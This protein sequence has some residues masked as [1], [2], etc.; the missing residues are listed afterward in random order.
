M[1]DKEKNLLSYLNSVSVL[2]LIYTIHSCLRAL[3]WTLLQAVQPLCIEI[4]IG[5]MRHQERKQ[6]LGSRG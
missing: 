4:S 6:T 2:H 3:A 1:P 5:F